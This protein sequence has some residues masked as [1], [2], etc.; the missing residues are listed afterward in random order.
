MKSMYPPSAVEDAVSEELVAW[1]VTVVFFTCGDFEGVGCLPDAVI[2]SV[3]EIGVKLFCFYEC[4]HIV[5]YPLF[6]FVLFFACF[7]TVDSGLY[8]FFVVLNAFDY[9]AECV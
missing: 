4:V 5:S 3:L 6:E 1:F 2:W 8:P 7:E 9:S